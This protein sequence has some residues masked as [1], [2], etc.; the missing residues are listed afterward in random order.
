MK[1]AREFSLAVESHTIVQVGESTFVACL[2][3][4]LCFST[5]ET[6]NKEQFKCKDLHSRNTQDIFVTL[7]VSKL[8]KYNVVNDVQL[9]N[10]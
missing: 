5:F 8:L 9:K 3:K 4:F 10:I 6:S 1:A 2:L 7:L